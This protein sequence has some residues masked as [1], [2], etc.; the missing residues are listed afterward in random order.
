MLLR[1]MERFCRK[2][3]DIRAITADN[4][5]RGK[6]EREH[7]DSAEMVVD[8]HGQSDRTEGRREDERTPALDADT[9]DCPGL[10]D[11]ERDDRSGDQPAGVDNATLVRVVCDC[12]EVGGVRKR[13]ERD[14]GHQHCPAA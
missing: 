9:R 6:H 1:I 10:P 14:T 12:E 8:Q 5:Q 11:G 2:I 4:R 7:V 13:E 3:S